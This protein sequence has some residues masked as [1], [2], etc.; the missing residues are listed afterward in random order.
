MRKILLIGTAVVALS[1]VVTQAN[2]SGMFYVTPGF[3]SQGFDGDRQLDSDTTASI[4]VGYNFTD[5]FSS[6]LVYSTLTADRD[7]VAGVD[8]DIEQLR[9]DGLYHF[10]NQG[11]WRPFLVG[12]IG[13]S[14]VEVE[15]LDDD[16]ETMV[17]IGGGLKYLF[18]DEFSLRGDIRGFQSLDEALT[19]FGIN[20]NLQLNFGGGSSSS[21]SKNPNPL[22]AQ[23]QPKKVEPIQSA[24]LMDSDADGVSDAADRCPGTRQGVVVDSMGCESDDDGDGVVNYT[25]SCPGTPAGVRVNAVG[26]QLTLKENIEISLNIEFDNDSAKTRKEHLKEIARIADLM[27]KHPNATLMIEGHSDSY[28]D[29]NYNKSLSQR[30]ANS[31]YDVLV[32]QFGIN[33]NRIKALGFGEERPVA[34]NE[35]RAGRQKNRRVV[36]ILEATIEKEVE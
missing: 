27:E 25:D 35:T 8:V 34:S 7:D 17:N 3:G 13:D 28:G 26:C 12:G 22:L 18:S 15:N 4:G 6:E 21:K 2:D 31:V 5:N 23:A 20:L 14:V 30:R 29:S 33:T 11:K 19:D 24:E 9:L 10:T 32:K 36:A 16:N 1:P